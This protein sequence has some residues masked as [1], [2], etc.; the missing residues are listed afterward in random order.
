MRQ[1]Q[2]QQYGNNANEQSH[3]CKHQQKH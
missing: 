3:I 2:K 1:Q